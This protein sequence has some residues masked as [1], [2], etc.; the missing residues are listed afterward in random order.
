M[1]L[2]LAG[3]VAAALL[4]LNIEPRLGAGIFQMLA[5][6]GAFAHGIQF[7]NKPITEIPFLKDEDYEI[8]ND[9]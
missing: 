2:R 7:S 1:W 9:Q 5:C 8:K 3:I 4:D 6:P